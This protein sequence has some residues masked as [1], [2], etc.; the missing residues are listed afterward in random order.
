MQEKSRKGVVFSGYPLNHSS[1]IVFLV[2][3]IREKEGG[4]SEG[5]NERAK[6]PTNER[7]NKHAPQQHDIDQGPVLNP[8]GYIDIKI[9][10]YTDS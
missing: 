5:A 2:L 3:G 1:F 4:S 9:Y 6:E 8:E 10:R 7:T